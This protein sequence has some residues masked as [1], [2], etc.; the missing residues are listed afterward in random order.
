[1]AAIDAHEWLSLIDI[2]GPFL[3]PPVLDDKFPQGFDGLEG[4]KKTEIRQ[5]YEEWVEAIDDDDPEV[6]ALHG[7]WIDLVLKDIL[8]WDE[9]RDGESLK[10]AGPVIDALTYENLEHGASV[11]PSYVLVDDRS[12]DQPFIFVQALP[13]GSDLDAAPEG[14]GWAASHTERLIE[15]LRHNEQRLG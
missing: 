1:M 14:S 12:G 4:K 7:A 11:S 6:E 8:E 3:A 5:A 10:R 15:L 9:N 2:S 13:P